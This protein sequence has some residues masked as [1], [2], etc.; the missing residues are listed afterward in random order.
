MSYR[1]VLLDPEQRTITL[2]RPLLLDLGAVA[3]GL[4]VDAAG[5]ELEPFRD[6]AIDAG[7]DLFLGG[8]NPQG[9]PGRLGFD[10]RGATMN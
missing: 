6:F 1:D 10:T 7:G 8:S 4:A 3:K 9:T 5:R 2:R